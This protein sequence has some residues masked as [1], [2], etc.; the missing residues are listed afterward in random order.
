MI[1]YRGERRSGANVIGR[2]SE[3]AATFVHRA[4]VNGWRWLEATDDSG[5]VVGSIGPHPDTGR[6]IWWAER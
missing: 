1:A 5:E 6:R 3:A 2:T 4:Y